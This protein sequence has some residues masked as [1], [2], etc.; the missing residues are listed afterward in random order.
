M[1]GC[2]ERLDA[3]AGGS[4]G[5]RDAAAETLNR[6]FTDVRQP[7]G[8]GDRDARWLQQRGICL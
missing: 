2:I 4:A 5:T 3:Q 7:E 6:R 1:P 8:A